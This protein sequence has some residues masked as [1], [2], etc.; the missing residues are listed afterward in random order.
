MCSIMAAP[1]RSEALAQAIER[2]RSWTETVRRLGYAGNNTRTVK[3]YAGRGAYRPT[4]STPKRRAGKRS[5]HGSPRESCERRLPLGSR[6][7]SSIRASVTARGSAGRAGIARRITG[8]GRWVLRG[9]ARGRRSVRLTNSWYVRS[10]ST[11]IL[12]SVGSTGSATTQSANGSASTS[13]SGRSP[14]GGIRRWSRSRGGR[15]RTGGVN[16]TPPDGSIVGCCPYLAR[17]RPLQRAAG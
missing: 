2:S 14:R 17:A 13:A 12:R 5:G 11:D 16:R 3:K 7:L 1:F 8:A 9:S 4:T 6:F 10:M 15:G